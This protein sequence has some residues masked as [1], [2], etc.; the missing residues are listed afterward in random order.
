MMSGMLLF[1]HAKALLMDNR[2]TDN[3]RWGIVMTPDCRAT[4]D[5]EVLDQSNTFLPNPRG[6]V[7]VTENPLSEIGR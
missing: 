3:L 7:V 1:H 5:R 2:C 4:P 6:A